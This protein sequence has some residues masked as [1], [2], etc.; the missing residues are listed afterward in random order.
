[1][2]RTAVIRDKTILNAISCTWTQAA[3]LKLD[4]KHSIPR[5]IKHVAET[6]SA[7]RIRDSYLTTSSKKIKG[8]VRNFYVQMLHICILWTLLGML[9]PMN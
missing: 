7:C 4:S 8:N 9:M 1:M 6:K 3:D 5:S 2:K